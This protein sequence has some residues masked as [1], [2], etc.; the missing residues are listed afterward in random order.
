V[1]RLLQIGHRYDNHRSATGHIRNSIPFENPLSQNNVERVFSDVA[2]NVSKWGRCTLSLRNK[3][4]KTPV[5]KEIS[6]LYFRIAKVALVTLTEG[7]DKISPLDRSFFHSSELRNDEVAL[8]RKYETVIKG[9]YKTIEPICMQGEL[10][11]IFEQCSLVTRLKHNIPHFMRF[12]Y[13][14]VALGIAEI[15]PIIFFGLLYLSVLFGLGLAHVYY[16]VFYLC[17]SEVIGTISGMYALFKSFPLL[18]GLMNG[19][20]RALPHI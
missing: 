3:L 19:P 9:I 5:D 14:L 15:A 10:E 6:K 1:L 12:L 13:C 16:S 18:V 2:V 4:Q 11:V 7:T 20:A 8:N 17:L